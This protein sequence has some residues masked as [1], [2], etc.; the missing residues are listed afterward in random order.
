MLQNIYNYLTGINYN[1]CLPCFEYYALKT[2]GMIIKKKK[3]TNR[4]INY[5]Y[6]DLHNSLVLKGLK[7]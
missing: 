6:R 3:I 5:F 1:F 4:A 7:S 2:G